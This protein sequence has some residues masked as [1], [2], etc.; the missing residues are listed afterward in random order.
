MPLTCRFN[1]ATFH[2]L[3]F[4]LLGLS[5]MIVPGVASE[6]NNYILLTPLIEKYDLRHEKETLTGRESFSGNGYQVVLCPGMAT[7][8]VN[9]KLIIL[10]ERAKSINGTIALAKPDEAK[11]ETLLKHSTPSNYNPETTIKKVVIDPGHGGEYRGCR[12]TNGLLE[13]NL[14]LDIG[15]KLRD[16]LEAKGIK[17][18]MTR[19]KDQQLSPNLN[20]D[21]NQRAAIANREQPDLFLSIHANWCKDTKVRGFEVY[22]CD[23]KPKVDYRKLNPANFGSI[24]SSNSDVAKVLATTLNG[25]YKKQ[26][27][28]LSKEIQKSFK[29]LTENR[30][31]RDRNFR[32]IKQTEC[33]AILVE[34]EYLSNKEASQELSQDNYRNQMA[35][36]LCQAIINFGQKIDFSR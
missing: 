34:I 20:E 9:D 2:I 14:V 1:P 12:A 4:V 32:V 13:K 23:R 18:V 36:K 7:M 22:Y 16:L 31:I 11:L 27:L 35:E 28:D 5:L 3:F 21:L 17:V 19:E 30:G 25:E 6:Q 24:T 29:S 8:L 26:T 15:L 33:P 10:K